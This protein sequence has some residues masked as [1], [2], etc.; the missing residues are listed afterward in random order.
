MSSFAEL[1]HDTQA[2]MP[3]LGQSFKLQDKSN[4]SG[5]E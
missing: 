2:E 3:I 4:G 1:L 5:Q